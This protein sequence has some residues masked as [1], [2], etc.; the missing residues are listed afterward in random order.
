MTSCVTTF[1][2]GMN[3]YTALDRVKDAPGR[4]K[5]ILRAHRLSDKWK[6]NGDIQLAKCLAMWSFMN[7]RT[8]L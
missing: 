4:M 2:I 7:V 3:Q 8:V 6:E 5:G 1:L